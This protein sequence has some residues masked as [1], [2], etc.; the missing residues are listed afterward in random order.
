[1]SFYRLPFLDRWNHFQIWV[2]V[3]PAVGDYSYMW[4]CS[5]YLNLGYLR[6]GFPTRFTTDLHSIPSHFLL[7]LHPKVNHELYTVTRSKYQS[8]GWSVIRQ[9]VFDPMYHYREHQSCR[10]ARCCDGY[11]GLKIPQLALG[12]GAVLGEKL[13]SISSTNALSFYYATTGHFYILWILRD[14]ITLPH[15]RCSST[16]NTLYT[17]QC[18]N[19]MVWREPIYNALRCATLLDSRHGY[20]PDV[21]RDYRAI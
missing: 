4:P 17:I 15:M 1:M 8:C 14:T 7:Q 18:V 16:V 11:D 3:W 19:F 13:L 21:R 5:C 12:L 9:K 10:Y 6:R 2:E 20:R